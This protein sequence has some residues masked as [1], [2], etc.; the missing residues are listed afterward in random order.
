MYNLWHLRE[1]LGQFTWDLVLRKFRGGNFSGTPCSFLLDIVKIEDSWVQPE[2]KSLKGTVT[3][4]I[5]I[6]EY[7]PNQCVY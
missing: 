1:I 5:V 6:P 2:Y 3:C 4:D 7:A